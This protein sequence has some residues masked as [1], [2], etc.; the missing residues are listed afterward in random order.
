ME[1]ARFCINYD[2]LGFRVPATC[3]ESGVGSAE[4]ELSKTGRSS[5]E[6]VYGNCWATVQDSGRLAPGKV[7]RQTLQLLEG[8]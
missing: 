4:P 8:F 1:H 5:G 7:A 3:S 6:T 2:F